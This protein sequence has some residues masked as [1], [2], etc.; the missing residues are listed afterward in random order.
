MSKE[1]D[2]WKAYVESAEK[3]KDTEDWE[4]RSPSPGQGSCYHRLPHC[5]GCPCKLLF[6]FLLTRSPD[7]D[8]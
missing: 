3:W 1:P 8:R 2:W 5:H 6:P 4:A 7:S